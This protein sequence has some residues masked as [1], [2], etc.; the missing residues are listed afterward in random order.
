MTVTTIVLPSKKYV[1]F[2]NI[3]KLAFENVML[4]HRLETS[5]A[6]LESLYQLAHNVIRIH[7]TS[8][9]T[10]PIVSLPMGG[11]IIKYMVNFFAQ[12]V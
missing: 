9:V 10:L 1:L 6:P 8:T 3:F 5:L 11:V 12:F 2:K 4:H 7:Y